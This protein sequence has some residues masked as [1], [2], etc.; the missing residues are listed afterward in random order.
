LYPDSLQGFGVSAFVRDD[1]AEELLATPRNYVDALFYERMAAG[2]SPVLRADE[3][4]EA[5]ASDALNLF[6]PNYAMRHH[7]FADPYVHRVLQTTSA[8]FYFFHAGYRLRLL[9]GEVFGPGQT[10][11]M[12]RGGFREI[13]TSS[14]EP[15]VNDVDRPAL[16]AMRREWIAPSAVHPLS[17][18]FHS[19]L[20]RIFFSAAEQRIL[21]RALLSRSDVEIA[22]DLG[23]SSDAVKKT[24]RRIYERVEG[25]LPSVTTA[26]EHG[27]DEAKRSEKRRHL[28]DYLRVNLE[29]TRPWSR[30]AAPHS[31]RNA[32]SGS[33]RDARRA[34]R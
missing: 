24:W 20:P 21:L 2:R 19:P 29:E 27:N 31:S 5:N 1:F 9:I 22:R 10:Q 14:L 13:A 8:S 28:L 30:K 11:Y 32:T 4:G 7:D 23:V 34:G 26:G 6:V 12:Q 25:K 3:V 17:F 16:F 15:N 33:I 18:L